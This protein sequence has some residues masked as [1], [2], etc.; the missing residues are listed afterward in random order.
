MIDP[1]RRP[2]PIRTSR[3]LAVLA[4]GCAAWACSPAVA[5]PVRPGEPSPKYLELRNP[6]N[7]TLR[8]TVNIAAWDNSSR[9][10]EKQDLELDVWTIKSAAVVFPLVEHSA[11]SEGDLK[12]VVSRLTFD[13][14]MVDDQP[15][16]ITRFPVGAKYGRWDFLARGSELATIR[17]MELQVSLPMVCS[18]TVFHE[19]AARQLDW[20]TEDWPPIVKSAF[21]PMSYVDHDPARGPYDMTPVRALLERW[22]DGKDPKSIKPV[23]LAKYLCGKVV[24]HVQ[25]TGEGLAFGRSGLLEGIAVR[26]PPITATQ[27]RGSSFDIATLLCAVYREAGLPARVVI[28]FDAEQQGTQDNAF[29]NN[30]RRS[31][32]YTAWVEFALYDQ[33]D[34]SV[35]WIPVDPYNIRRLQSR[36]PRDFLDRPLE[37]FGTNRDLDGITPIS[38]FFFPPT[39]VRSYGGSGTPAFWGWFVAPTP[40]TRAWQFLR[41]EGLVTA[42][43]SGDGQQQR[44]RR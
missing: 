18:E 36:L 35:T 21:Q 41:F 19:D 7:W 34:G 13:D 5:Q 3:A 17:E 2:V 15:Q 29:L 44:R 20:P 8:T 23:V 4:A 42:T 28:G 9:R 16:I 10:A 1:S 27:R 11:A 6:K 22:T 12:G 37:Y 33:A 14:R 38:F 32:L 26:P 30:D 39:T 40:P 24:E 31:Q 25:L 43:R